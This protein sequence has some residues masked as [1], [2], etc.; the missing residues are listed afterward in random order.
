MPDQ[1]DSSTEV[2]VNH[3]PPLSAAANDVLA[4]VVVLM[5]VAG[6]VL[7]WR[8]IRYRSRVARRPPAARVSLPPASL[9]EYP[10]DLEEEAA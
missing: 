7:L 10:R 8:R 4:F 3:G 9:E 6:I 5:F 1:S 2:P